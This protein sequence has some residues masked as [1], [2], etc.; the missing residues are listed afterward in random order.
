MRYYVVVRQYGKVLE[1]FELSGSYA[2]SQ[3]LQLSGSEISRAM[4]LAEGNQAVTTGYYDIALTSDP[5]DPWRDVDSVI[6][7]K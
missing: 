2:I 7:V 3:N 6:E 5:E 4:K 1:Q